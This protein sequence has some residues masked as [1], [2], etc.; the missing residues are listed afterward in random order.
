MASLASWGL[1]KSILSVIVGL[2]TLGGAVGVWIGAGAWIRSEAQ[3]PVA[4]L[5][6]RHEDHEEVADRRWEVIN[7]QYE[8][9]DRK[10]DDMLDQL[11]EGDE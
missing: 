8:S 2:G 11:E 6:E 10:L 3:K 7:R 9:I 5:E 4:E 1:G